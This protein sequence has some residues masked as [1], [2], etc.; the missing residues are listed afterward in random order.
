MASSTSFLILLYFCFR[1]TIW[2][3]RILIL[4]RCFCEP[5]LGH[6][7]TTKCRF[8]QCHRLD[9]CYIIKTF[10]NCYLRASEHY[11]L[12]CFSL[13]LPDGHWSHFPLEQEGAQLAGGAKGAF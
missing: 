2:I 4:Y 1:S 10:I 8:I 11:L 5:R 7:P 9:H 12:S 6:K 13:G 3:G